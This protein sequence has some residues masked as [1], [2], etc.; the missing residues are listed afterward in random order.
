MTVICSKFVDSDDLFVHSYQF[1]SNPESDKALICLGT[2]EK[3]HSDQSR[4][5]QTQNMI[6]MMKK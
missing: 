2:V 6:K 4:L 5:S 3:Q 1:Q